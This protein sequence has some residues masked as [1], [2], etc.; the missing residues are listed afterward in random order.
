M[1]RIEE[2][3]IK[4]LEDSMFR[5][6]EDHFSDVPRKN[7]VLIHF[8]R[9]SKRRLGSI[10][11]ADNNTR[12]KYLLDR[13]KEILDIDDDNRVTVITVTRYFEDPQIPDHVVDMTIAHEIVHYSH[14]FHS[15]LPKLYKVPHQGGIVKKELSKR[16]LGEVV[17]SS[18]RWL[19]DN[20]YSYLSSFKGNKK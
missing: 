4:Y 5:L 16:G 6:W 1:Q 8:G 13:K 7:L 11:W 12:I 17:S 9:Y 18:E 2:R 10:K 19:K 14:G 3:D 15:P 20:W